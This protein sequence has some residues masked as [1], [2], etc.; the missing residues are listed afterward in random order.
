MGRTSFGFSATQMNRIASSFRASKRAKERAELIAK[1]EG[2]YT[3]KAPSYSIVDFDFNKE[4]RVA[5]IGF[6]QT[7][8]YRKIEKYV[9]QN[10][11]KYPIY[12]DWNTR[13][14]LIKKTIKLTNETLE[15]LNNYEDSLV[16]D[17]SYEIVSRI[18]NEDYFPS[19]FINQTLVECKKDEINNIR[20]E[21]DQKNR[22]IESVILTDDKFVVRHKIIREE[23]KDELKVVK[24]Q[25][26]KLENSIC[27]AKNK[28][29][30]VF[31]SII[32]C[33]IYAIFHSKRRISRL[34]NKL[35]PVK[36]SVFDL[37]EKIETCDKYVKELEHNISSNYNKIS[38][39]KRLMNEE[40]QK[41]EQKYD[42]EILLIESL[43]T[44]LDNSNE[45]EFIPLKKLCGMSYE[46]I[47]GC[48][49]IH[50]IE[51]DRYYVGQSKDV[52]K[53]VC[54]QH[55]DG[56]KVKNIIF[57]EDYFTSE[58]ENKE[59]LFEV[60][61]IRLNTKDELDRK[62][63]ELIEEYDAFN[64]GYNGTSGNI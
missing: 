18:D 3:K 14:K 15:R 64:N 53:R 60:R 10:Y 22:A 57:A 35:K 17:F 30:F 21:Y 58:F 36:A 23:I 38:E 31:F 16:A 24:R 55:F 37:E 11:Q 43:P 51:K 45:S 1:N 4:S 28:N 25:V 48:Y 47:V 33:G 32:S 63:K 13:T 9:T 46:K 2:T 26:A 20:S 39:N 7:I 44:Y 8:E 29:N 41:V 52:L 34:E 56:T 42:D 12:S 40:F 50:N 6:E 59:D 19:W 49:V 54:K 27:K 5:H 62:E 61:I